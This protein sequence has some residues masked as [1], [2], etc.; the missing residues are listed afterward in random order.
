MA[1]SQCLRIYV[2]CVTVLYCD[3]TNII[4]YCFGY[5]MSRGIYQKESDP[6]NLDSFCKL[7][8][9]FCDYF[10]RKKTTTFSSRSSENYYKELDIR[11]MLER[12]KPVL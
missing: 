8:L 5:K 9:E 10:R 11:V 1:V 7:D 12:G 3:Y 4:P 2:L 6:K